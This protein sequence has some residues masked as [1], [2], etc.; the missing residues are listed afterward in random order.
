[1]IRVFLL[2]LLL[3]LFLLAQER[4]LFDDFDSAPADTN[5]WAYF[6]NFGGQHYQTNAN[7]DSAYGW[8]HYSY[9]TDPVYSG[10]GAFKMDYSV[11]N[12]EGWGGYTKIEHWNPDSNAVYD[13]S[14]YDSIEVWYYNAVPQT[15][16]GRVHFRF[17]LHDVSDSP[18]GNKT[19]SISDCEYW[20]SFHYI[21]DDEPG[22]HVFK[23]AL[24][25]GRDDP[26]SDEWGGESFNRTGWAGIAGNDKLDLD[27]IKGFSFEYS[28]S[29]AGEGDY[30][31]GTLIVDHI[32]L[33]SPA[34]K[35]FI[36]FNGKA[37]ANSLSTFTWGQS[38]I[39]VEEGA[40]P[41][42]G[43][44][45]IHW[46]PGDE[47]NNGWSGGGWNIDPPYDMSF[48]WATDSIKFKMKAE[49][50][51]GDLRIQIEDGNAKRGQVF[52]PVTDNQWHQYA[53]KLSEMPYQDGTSNFDSSHVSVLQFMTNGVSSKDKNI[54]I[55]DLWTGN[56]EIDVVPPA[57]PT[58]VSAIAADYYNLVI[59]EDVPGE[60]GETYTVYASDKP[61]SDVTAEGVEVI[62][63]KISEGTQSV[64]HFIYYP[65][66][67][68][69]VTE[70]YA[71]V[72]TDAAGN[73]SDPSFTD[74]VE[75]TAQGIPTISLTPPENFQADGDVSEWDPEVIKPFVLT[76][77]TSHVAGGSFDSDDDLTATIYLAVDDNYLYMA[78]DILDD[79]YSYDPEGNFWEDDIIEVYM[80]L[81]NFTRQHYGFERGDQPDYK[82][83]LLYDGFHNDQAG[84]TPAEF[85]N[86]SEFY[87]FT[88]MG[89][90][91]YVIECK[92]PLDS[93][94][95]RGAA[96]DARFHPVNGMRIPLDL[97]IHDSDHKNV[98]DGI[99]SYSNKNN[100]TSWQGAQFW[101]YTWIGDT[102]KVATAIDDKLHTVNTFR[103]E[104]NYPNPFNP[105]TT[106]AYSLGKNTQVEI[107]VYTVLG[108]KVAT[109]FNGHQTAGTHRITF[110]ASHLASGLY[111]YR[112][113]AGNFVQTRKM[114]L[115]K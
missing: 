77:S 102:N 82:F 111:L 23:M 115:M 24:K 92:I 69:K 97:V 8:I 42:P 93:I 13:W 26:N 106:I 56:P 72:C 65:L 100:D 48:S 109:L 78:F 49:D 91:D 54:Y 33:Y 84:F 86:P 99:L 32:T 41:E 110:D 5:F 79:V 75:N 85:A 58:G 98:R 70:Y 21:L 11:H 6:D 18:D 90:S 52:T 1:M 22:W 28:I 112:I 27:K 81:Y 61:F 89:A 59:W 103:L 44:N 108:Q 2:S 88:P 17:C 67:D 71:V 94:N 30:S 53:F 36:F 7:A 68:H 80:G 66:K 105:T 20:Y 4:V 114:L 3:P 39:K 31:Q 87:N 19:Y 46:I 51:V 83:V 29:G 74:P 12:K 60:E 16:P 35:S 9:V 50:G 101:S 47:W 38:T 62:G 45:A 107:A 25:D 57:A 64:A 40:G 55:T 10:A 43:T 104:Q 14:N 76:P 37:L 73:V 96:G 63:E 15:L 34:K 113:K 95:V